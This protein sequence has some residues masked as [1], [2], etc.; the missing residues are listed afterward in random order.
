[1][2]IGI[3][4]EDVFGVLINVAVEIEDIYLIFKNFVNFKEKNLVFRGL[5]LK[6]YEGK[7]YVFIGEFGFGK[8]VIIFLFY[9]FIGLNVIIEGGKIRLY[10]LEV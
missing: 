4:V 1:M 3:K 6:I 10:G 5:S 2:F 7:I 8:F 9:G